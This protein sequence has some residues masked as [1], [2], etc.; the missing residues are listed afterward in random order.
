[1][2]FLLSIPL[3]SGIT[4]IRWRSPSRLIS[5]S[6]ASLF[7]RR[8]PGGQYRY[9]YPLLLFSFGVRFRASFWIRA[10]YMSL[11]CSRYFF[12]SFCRVLLAPNGTLMLSLLP[13]AQHFSIF[14]G[15]PPLNHR[16]SLVFLLPT[17]GLSFS[18][19]LNMKRTCPFFLSS[20]DPPRSR[21]SFSATPCSSP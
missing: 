5:P 19:S 14:S 16:R 2:S 6:P 10:M 15:P 7:L 9:S 13:I 1:L 18:R 12:Y 21:S 3:E 8:S 17:P 20:S 4:P 11:L